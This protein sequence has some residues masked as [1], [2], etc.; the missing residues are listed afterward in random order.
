MSASTLTAIQTQMNFYGYPIIMVVGSIG[1]IFIPFL[2]I[3]QRQNPCV[4]YLMHSALTNLL[5]LLIPGFFKI[6]S[7]TYYDETLGALLCCKLTIYSATFLGQVAKTML[8]LACID[9]YLITNEQARFRAFST[10]KRAKYFVLFSYI[11]WLIGASHAAIWSTVTRGQCGK[12]GA[13]ATV[14]ALFSIFFVGLIP[15]ITICMFG[16]LTYRNMKK[17]RNRVQPT[18]QDANKSIQRRDRA[19]I[20]LV[21]AEAILYIVT[22]SLLPAVVIETTI[23][24]YTMENKSLQYLRAE[25]LALNV[26]FLLLFVY[27]AAPFYVYIISSASFRQDFKQLIVNCYRKLTPQAPTATALQRIAKVP[28]RDTRV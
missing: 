12:V 1:N 26:A 2:F 9:R 11:F 16:Y 23:S 4:I 25:I 28:Q 21:I 19:L 17:I 15:S 8:I 18:G 13:Y 5:Y 22:T 14:F 20:N 27:S 6:F 7:L 3:R 10:P 24:Q